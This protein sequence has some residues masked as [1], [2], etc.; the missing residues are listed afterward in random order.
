MSDCFN[1]K[2]N[3]FYTVDQKRLSEGMYMHDYI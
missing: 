3:M 2:L 1:G